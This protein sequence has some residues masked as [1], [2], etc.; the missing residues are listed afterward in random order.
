MKKKLF[1]GLIILTNSLVAS[2]AVLVCRTSGLFHKT[3]TAIS[4]PC[5]SLSSYECEEK[6][7]NALKAQY[8]KYNSYDAM[9]EVCDKLS[10]SVVWYPVGIKIR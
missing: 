9:N 1:L 7:K 8:N 6:L 4:M 10:S 5:N 2:N 3:H